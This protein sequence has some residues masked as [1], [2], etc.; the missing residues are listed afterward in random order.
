MDHFPCDSKAMKI[1]QYAIKSPEQKA[2]EEAA[3]AAADRTGQIGVP[4]G[5]QNMADEEAADDSKFSR[6]KTDLV[7]GSGHGSKL[8]FAVSGIQGQ[9]ER[10]FNETKDKVTEYTDAAMDKVQSCKVS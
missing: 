2:A 10:I 8:N 9:A 7:T 6:Y 3:S 4:P 5:L 1:I